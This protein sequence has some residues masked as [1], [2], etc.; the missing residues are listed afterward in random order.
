[1]SCEWVGPDNSIWLRFGEHPEAVD[2]QLN[3]LPEGN[4]VPEDEKVWEK[5]RVQYDAMGPIVIKVVALPTQ[6]SEI[7]EEFQPATWIAHALNGI[8]LMTVSGAEDVRRI[9]ARYR[10]VIERAPLEV[11]HQIGTFGLNAA[12]YALMK[13]MKD[14]FDPDARLNPGRHVDGEPV[15]QR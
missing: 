1:M 13:K 15:G 9:R 5:L 12:E 3:H 11:R 7:L 4:W 6:L 14:A 2:W 8:V 10:A